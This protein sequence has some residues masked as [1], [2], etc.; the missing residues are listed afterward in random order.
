MPNTNLDLSALTPVGPE[1][2]WALNTTTPGQ[3]SKPDGVAYD[4]QDIY[5]GGAVSA[6]FLLTYQGSSITG[7]PGLRADVI[8]NVTQGGNVL[9][10]QIKYGKSLAV[11]GTNISVSTRHSKA[12]ASGTFQQM[13]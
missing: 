6:T 11:S 4:G 9:P 10:I 2:T 5:I 12:L 3:A 7:F 1:K 13:V 8:I